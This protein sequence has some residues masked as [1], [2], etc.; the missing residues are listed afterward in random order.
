MEENEAGEIKPATSDDSKCDF[1]GGP[2]FLQFKQIFDSL[3][4]KASESHRRNGTVLSY[5]W[6]YFGGEGGLGFFIELIINKERRSGT[7]HANYGKI[8]VTRISQEL[9]NTKP[10]SKKIRKS[11]R[12]NKPHS[13]GL[14]QLD[15]FDLFDQPVA[16]EAPL[17]IA[18]PFTEWLQ[19]EDQKAKEKFWST[20]VVEAR[21]S[22]YPEVDEGKVWTLTNYP[23]NVMMI[24]G[25]WKDET[26]IFYLVKTAED[27]HVLVNGEKRHLDAGFEFQVGANFINEIIDRPKIER[28]QDPFPWD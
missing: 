6:K 5:Q 19:E 26:G 14:T 11:H 17:E 24:K 10:K 27:C 2:G 21:A 13:S 8:T 4:G 20:H 28:E 22:I 15:M 16:S 12:K 23:L 3:V 18:D 1:Y 25:P 7:G 9:N